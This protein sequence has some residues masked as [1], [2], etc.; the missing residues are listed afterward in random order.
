MNQILRVAAL[1]AASWVT[2]ACL[3]VLLGLFEW[4]WTPTWIQALPTL[5]NTPTAFALWIGIPTLL[6]LLLQ[7]GR[8]N[9]ALA[10]L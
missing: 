5:M 1:L 10:E 2:V 8:L 9:R 3:A 7:L 4:S 6:C